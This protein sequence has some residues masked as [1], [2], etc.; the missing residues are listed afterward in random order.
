[1]IC[2]TEGAEQRCAEC[3]EVVTEKMSNTLLDSLQ[4]M[5]D[6]TI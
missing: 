4:G 3:D 2:L 1:M 5:Q 6:N